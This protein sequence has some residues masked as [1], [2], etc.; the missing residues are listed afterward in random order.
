MTLLCG[1]Q[2]LLLSDIVLRNLER[3]NYYDV[4]TW[5][6]SNVVFFQTINAPWNNPK[7]I[8]CNTEDCYLLK[9]ILDY[10]QNPFVLLT[11]NS[12]TNVTEEYSYIYNHP[13]IHHWFTQN[14]I[15]NHPKVSF[16][17]IGKANPVWQHGTQYFFDL[18]SDHQNEKVN[19]FYAN[20]LVQTNHTKRSECQSA[21][22]SFGIQNNPKTHPV[23]FFSKL[24]ASLYSICPE[25][26]GIDTHRFW[27]SIY[28]K[29]LPVVIR[30]PFT[31]K[32]AQ[33]YPCCLISSWDKLFDEISPY[34]ASLFTPEIYSKMSFEY[35]KN[36][37]LLQLN[38]I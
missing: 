12:D 37:I 16:L 38:S 11:H 7:L 30:S 29:T 4:T 26:N 27:E 34:S 31:E 23:E 32:L 22:E 19:N 13:K 21:I 6:K 35:F 8:F 25:G 20:F 33:E 9:D 36:K 28:F 17:P 24:A 14:A 5:D 10:F 15:V 3:N 1:D 2:F 18:V